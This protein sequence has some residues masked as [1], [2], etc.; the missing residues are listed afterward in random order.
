MTSNSRSRIRYYQGQP[1]Q[2]RDLR[3][4]VAYEASMNQLHVTAL[5]NTWGVAVGLEVAVSDDRRSAVI[6]PGMAYDRCGQGIIN[7]STLTIPVP[8]LQVPHNARPVI[9]W[10]DL[11]IRYDDHL[12]S[13]TQGTTD[14]HRGGFAEERLKWRWILA[15]YAEDPAAQPPD[16]ASGVRVGDE[17]PLARLVVDPGGFIVSIDLSLR[18]TARAITR[19]YVATGQAFVQASVNQTD[20]CWRTTINTSAGGFSSARPRYFARL[21][22][23]PLRT[24]RNTNP[25]TEGVEGLNY[26]N[27]LRLLHGPFLS[28]TNPTRSSFQ[29]EVRLAVA[30][31]VPANISHMIM[32]PTQLPLKVSW[33]GMEPTGGCQPPAPE[34][35]FAFMYYMPIEYNMILFSGGGIG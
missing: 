24:L 9:W 5:H 27:V 35:V 2:A 11:V 16:L 21:L 12:T 22:E 25:D 33:Q 32:M 31:Q 34:M 10:Y 19:P 28:I 3:D 17:V 30:S 20:L 1:L 14:C 23:H 15:G 18:R 4:E 6:G 7:P 29:L 13:E 8:P 26:P